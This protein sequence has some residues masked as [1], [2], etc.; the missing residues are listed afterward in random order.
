MVSLVA[1]Q[2]TR[3]ALARPHA[4][5]VAARAPRSENQRCVRAVIAPSAH[6]FTVTESMLSRTGIGRRPEALHH[7]HPSPTATT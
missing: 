1:A 5:V 7:P 6:K 4:H 3:L 2:E